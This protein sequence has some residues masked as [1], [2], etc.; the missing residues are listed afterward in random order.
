M[1]GIVPGIHGNG[2]GVFPLLRISAIGKLYIT[3]GKPWLAV[4]LRGDYH[5][6]YEVNTMKRL[7]RLILAGLLLPILLGGCVAG[8]GFYDPGYYYQEPDGYYY[9]YGHQGRGR[10]Y[11]HPDRF[12]RHGDRY[13][14]WQER[15]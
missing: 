12:E 4:Y 15:R 2:L 3:F 11:R 7:K 13:D 6:T 8:Y 10:Y 9:Y 14:R 5:L 1:P